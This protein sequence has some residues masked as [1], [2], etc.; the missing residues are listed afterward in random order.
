MFQLVHLRATAPRFDEGA[1][2]AFQTQQRAFLAS[3]GANPAGA[4]QDTLQRTLF[5]DHPRR[6]RFAQQLD[7]VGALT[8]AQLDRVYRDRFA[9]LSDATFTVVGATDVPTVQRLAETYLATLPGGGRDDAW[10][11][12]YPD[13]PSGTIEKAVYKGAAP[14]SQVI[15]LFH[16]DFASTPETRRR[17]D[18]LAGVMSIRLREKIREELGGVYGIQAQAVTSER[19]DQTYQFIVAFTCDPQRVDEL[20]A[21]VRAE[22]AAVIA[23]RPERGAGLDG[24]GAGAARARDG[25]RTEPVLALAPRRRLHVGRHPR[26]RAHH[27]LRRPRRRDDGPHGAG[28]RR[29]LPRPHRRP[30]ARR[31]LPRVDGACRAVRGWA[32]WFVPLRPSP[33]PHPPVV[34]LCGQT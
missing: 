16:G 25:P 6:L 23:E 24:A 22:I 19:P 15:L 12:V 2:A 27:G 33:Q 4:L 7:A 20:S 9:D 26:A 11:D 1:L 3:I 34:T 31:P 21:A 5:G 13:L 17:I 18:G 8:T 28:R 14:Q 30:R 10:R 32:R 29:A